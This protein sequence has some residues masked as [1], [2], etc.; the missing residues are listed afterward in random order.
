GISDSPSIIS[1]WMALA[2]ALIFF[3]SAVALMKSGRKIKL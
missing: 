2:M 1:F 3:F